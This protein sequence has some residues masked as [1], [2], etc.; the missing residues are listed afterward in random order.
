MM[1]LRLVLAMFSWIT[2]EANNL[3]PELC[4]ILQIQLILL[5]FLLHLLGIVQLFSYNYIDCI[6]LVMIIQVLKKQLL[7][8]KKTSQL[9]L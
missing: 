3:M 4:Y 6:S 1:D 5:L 2:P 8:Q 7:A 9:L